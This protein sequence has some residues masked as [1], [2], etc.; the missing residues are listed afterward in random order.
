MGEASQRRDRAV[1]IEEAFAAVVRAEIAPV[2][3]EL[4][5]LRAE[6][7]AMRRTLPPMLVTMEEAAR[8]MDV[9]VA[10]VRRQIRSGSIPVRRIGRSVRVDLAS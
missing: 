9:S 6:V 2:V 10:T 7:A 5:Q 8:H 1:S 3:A 4:R